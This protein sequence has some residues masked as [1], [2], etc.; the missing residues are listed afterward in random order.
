MIET[1]HYCTIT[2]ESMESTRPSTTKTRSSRSTGFHDT[3]QTLNWQEL[4]DEFNERL[5]S[6]NSPSIGFS[7]HSQREKYIANIELSLQKII[8]YALSEANALLA[9]GDYFGAL[10]GGLKALQFTQK[11]Y[12]TNSIQQIEPYFLIAKANQYLKRFEQAEEFLS[13]ANWTIIKHEQS[14]PQ[15]KAELHQ[16]FGLLY[17]MEGKID[18]AI[19]HLAQ[20]VSSHFV[21]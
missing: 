8:E 6:L 4:E 19:L 7:S 10:K 20:S 16:N 15:L 11:V 18:E 13:I 14:S 21:S 1:N 9:E 5:E 12:G 3:Q 17:I 2:V